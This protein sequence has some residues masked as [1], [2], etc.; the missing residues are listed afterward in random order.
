MKTY[1]GDSVFAE[2][3]DDSILLKGK[4]GDVDVTIQLYPDT[5]TNLL[6]WI[7]ELKLT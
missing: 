7:K 6:R 2:I 4:S 3:E 1:L 5:I